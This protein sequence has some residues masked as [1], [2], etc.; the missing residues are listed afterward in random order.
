MEEKKR[1]TWM[2]TYAESAYVQKFVS[3]LR[4]EPEMIE[5]FRFQDFPFKAL[6]EDFS[7][8]KRK[9]ILARK[10]ADSDYELPF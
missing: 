5:Y 3:L 9:G 2:L 8:Q 4:E 1:R 7:C 6:I 10:K